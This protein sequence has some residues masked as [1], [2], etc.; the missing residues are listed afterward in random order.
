M[1]TPVAGTVTWLA[2]RGAGTCCAMTNDGAAINA[3]PESAT[4][5]RF[6]RVLFV[7]CIRIGVF[8]QIKLKRCMPSWSPGAS[9][10]FVAERNTTMHSS[11]TAVLT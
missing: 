11:A 3:V 8:S 10:A 5:A 6:V 7:I 1:T 2:L 9:P 4:M